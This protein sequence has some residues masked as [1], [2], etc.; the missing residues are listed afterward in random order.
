VLT[1]YEYD[2]Q[3][4]ISRA[5]TASAWTEEDRALMLARDAYLATL[6]RG[7]GQPKDQAWHP[8]NEGWYEVS[9]SFECHACTALRREGNPSAE[10]VVF[11][12]VTDTRD[13]EKDPLPPMP[14]G[15]R[16]SPDELADAMGG[17]E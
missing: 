12:A 11:H 13:Y 17:A 2:D 5:Y 16:L 1:T 14:V 15:T 6:C 10:P 7:C 8:D 4:R 9:A 3:G